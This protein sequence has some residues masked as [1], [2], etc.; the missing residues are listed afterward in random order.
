MY[1]MKRLISVI[2]AI[3]LCFTLSACLGNKETKSINVYFKDAQSGEL[4]IEQIKYNGSQNTVDMANFALKHLFEGPSNNKLMKTL[5]EETSLLSLSV[6][7][8]VATVDFSREFSSYSGI[9]DLLARFSVVSTLCDIPGITEVS[10][11]IEGNP[12]VSKTTGNEIGRLSKKDVVLDI[13]VVDSP[14]ATTTITMYF[15][16]SDAM[17]LKAE[18]RNVKTQNTISIEKTIMNELL[19]GPS[20]HELTSVMPTGTKV[21]NVETKDSVCYVNLSVDFVSKFP[22]G[23]GILTVYSVVNSLCSL[24]SVQS[25]Q[26]LIE[27]EKGAEFGNFVFDEPIEANFDIVTK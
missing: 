19:K 23:S 22:G 12:L 17:G 21:L 14:S 25:V 10:I 11:T 6:K 20:S 27:G 4:T 24:E 15:A 3:L 26:I 8:G 2:T 18:T 9:D 1:F 7:D 13:D 16:T 5:P